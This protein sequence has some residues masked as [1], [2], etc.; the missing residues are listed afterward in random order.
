[1]RTNT[2]G[3]VLSEQKPVAKPKI[4]KEKEKEPEPEVP[5]YPPFYFDGSNA[6]GSKLCLNL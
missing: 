3:L 5:S 4:K 2:T 1:V 6:L